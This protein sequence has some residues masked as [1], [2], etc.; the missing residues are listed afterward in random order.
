MRIGIYGGSFDPIHHGHLV[1]AR[2]AMEK[3]TLDEVRF[4]PAAI[5][6]FKPGAVM[7]PVSLRADMIATAIGGQS[8]FVLDDR[9]L[10]RPGPSFAIDTVRD[11][12]REMPGAEWFYFIGADNVADLPLWREWDA[13]ADLVQFVVFP[14]PGFEVPSGISLPFVGRNIGISS[15][16][17]R[18]RVANGLSIRYL[19]TDRVADIIQRAHIYR[20][21]EN[22]S[23]KPSN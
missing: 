22:S 21:K 11:M 23:S 5:S 2:D 6:P 10:H 12:M 15:T 13:L 19:V 9:E 8:G 17:I 4:V 16:E 18:E 7:S 20:N 1:L 14:R 3:F